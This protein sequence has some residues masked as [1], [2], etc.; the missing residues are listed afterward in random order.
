MGVGVTG[1]CVS[2]FS[3]AVAATLASFALSPSQAQT[4]LKVSLDGR[5]DSQSAP[6]FVALERGYFKAEAL[7]VS[8]E[9]SASGTEPFTR[10]AS[11]GFDVAI[12][13]INAMI[14]YRDQNANPSTLKAVFVINNR[15]GYAIVGRVSRGVTSPADLDEKRLGAPAAEPASSAWPAFARLN[16]VDAAKVRVVNVGVP[17]RDPMLIAGELDAV[18]GTSSATPINLREKGVP[19]DDI[20]TMLM[21]SYGLEMYGQSVIASGKLLAEKPEAIRAFLRAFMRGLKDTVANPGNGVDAVLRRGNGQSRELE[22]ER[23]RI[24]IRDSITTAEARMNGAGGVDPVRFE[25]AIG[26]IAMGY[27]FKARPKVADVFDASFLPPDEER[28]IE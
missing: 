16:A 11:G 20:S 7:D 13:D 10:V 9:T 26:Q 2:R 6:L 18:T 24:I 19:A 28:R 27:T 22:L 17:V 25:A 15:P 14:R 4:P 21:A 3:V 1:R 12:G 23:L 8:I 5:I